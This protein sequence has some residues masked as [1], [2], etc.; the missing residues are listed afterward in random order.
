MTAFYV[1]R[2][3]FMTFWGNIADTTRTMCT[4][5]RCP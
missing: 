4:N 5:R 2:A 3:M 1:W